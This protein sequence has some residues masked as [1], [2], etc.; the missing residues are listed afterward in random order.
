MTIVTFCGKSQINS[1]AAFLYSL[2][3]QAIALAVPIAGRN[4]DGVRK[5]THNL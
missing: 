5:Y 2:H 4:S 3:E 1:R